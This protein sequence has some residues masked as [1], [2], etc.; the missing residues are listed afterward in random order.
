MGSLAPPGMFS[1]RGRQGTFERAPAGQ[2]MA[3]A[4]RNNFFNL[5]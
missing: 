1:T 5:A 2:A 3:R 4:A